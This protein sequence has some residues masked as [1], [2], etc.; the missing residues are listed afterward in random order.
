MKELCVIYFGQI[1]HKKENQGLDHHR[2]EQDFI[3]DK[4]SVKNSIIEIT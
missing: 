3:G 2:E 4:I 1:Q